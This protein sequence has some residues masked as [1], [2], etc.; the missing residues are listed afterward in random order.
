MKKNLPSFM[1][2]VV[3]VALSILTG[4]TVYATGFNLG[5]FW[6][7]NSSV[8]P[9]SVSAVASV[10]PNDGLAQAFLII[11]PRD[12]G[13]IPY[14]AGATVEV[15]SS[16][17]TVTMS[18]NGACRT[19]NSY[20][21]KAYDAGGGYYYAYA[22]SSTVQSPTFSTV[23]A[24]SPDYNTGSS[25]GVTFDTSQYTTIS[26]NTTITN[27]AHGGRNLY[28]TGGTATF[29]STTVGQTFGI[30][31][32]RGGTIKH[33]ATTTA[34]MYKLDVNAASLFLQSGSI[35][36]DALGYTVT[37]SF[38]PTTPAT[39]FGPSS[40][41]AGSHG[42]RGGGP[43]GPTGSV[44]GAP[45]DDYRNPSY[46]GGG[47][48]SG[49]GIGGG[50][51]RI[52]ASGACAVQSGATIT[53]NAGASSGP[54][55]AGG[56]VYLNCA[57]FAGTAG[58]NAITAKGI[59]PT[60]S[61]YSG[62]GGRIAL[63]STGNAANFTGNFNYNAS[64]STFKTMVNA[65]GGRPFSSSYGGGGAG[66][67]Y[68]KHTGLT[69]GD[70]I[71]NNNSQTFALYNRN[72]DLVS[73]YGT[74]NGAPGATTLPISSTPTLTNFVNFYGGL[75]LRPDLSFSNGTASD[76]SDDNVLT[77]A[78]N[79][80]TTLTMNA[81]FSGVANGASFR[82][83][84]MFDHLEVTDT[85]V[86]NSYGDIYV[87]SGSLTSPGPAL[88]LTNA[89]L[90]FNAS[91]SVNPS[92]T[93]YTLSSGNYTY[94]NMTGINITALN[95]VLISGATVN[96]G[97]MT[98]G[99][100][101]LSSGTVTATTISAGAMSV[102]GGTN[103]LQNIGTTGDLTI[104]GGTMNHPA[105]DTTT[106]Y[107]LQATVGGNFLMSGGSINTDNLGYTAGYSFGASGPSN[108]LIP[109]SYGGSHGGRGG[110]STTGAAT[111]S[112]FDDY[113]N[114]NYPGGGGGSGGGKGGGVVR[115]TTTGSCTVNSGATITANAGSNSANTG[116]GGS[117]Y[118]NCASF[119]G[120]AGAGAITAKSNA[121]TGTYF[122]GGGGRIA[123]I[124]AGNASSFTGNFDYNGALATFKSMVNA[125]GGRPFNT[126]YGGGGAG[127]I[128]IKHSGLTYGDML[129][130]NN[131]QTY[132][133]SN[134]HTDLLSMYGTVNA[135][136]GATTLPVSAT[137]SVVSNYVNVYA[138]MKVRPDLAFT[139]GTSTDWSDDNVLTVASNNGSG[140]L[141]M[142][143]S[144]SGVANGASF[145]SIDI[146]DHLEV[147][148]T[149]VVNSYGDIYVLNGSLTSPG[150][151]L[152]LTNALLIFNGSASINP[153][154]S[155]YTFS[156][157]D[158]SYTAAQGTSP[159]AQNNIVV[160]G[161]IVNFATVTAGSFSI[162][163][164][165]MLATTISAGSVGVSG[166]T[167][168][169]Q[170]ITTTGDLTISGG[171]VNHPTTTTT[172]V[173]RLQATVGGNFLMSGGT[174]NVTALGYTAGYSFGASGPSNS[175]IPASYGG[176]HGGR[177]G[178]STTGG[179][180]AAPF[181]D[182]RNPNYPG[183]G[184]G[185][186]GSAGGGVVR[187][188]ATGSCTINSGA[189]IAAN[190]NAWSGNTGAGGSIYL[191][192][193]SFAGTAG[194]GAITAKSNASTSTYFSG[195]GGR[196]ALISTGNAASF[197]GNFAYTTGLTTFKSMVNAE[198]G[199]PYNSGYGGGGAGTIYIKHSGLTYG[200]M[201]INNN[202][203]TYGASNANTDLISMY[204]TVNGAPGATTL[205]VSSTPTLASNY[206]N[207]Y[208]GMRLRPDLTYTN[209]TSSDWTDDNVLTVASN[210]SSV[211][212]MTGSFSG[213]A[214][215][216]SFRSIDIFD[217]LEVSDTSVVNSYGDIYVLSGSLTS[218]GSMSL[219]NAFIT[220]NGS[221]SL[222]PAVNDYTFSSGTVG[223]STTNIA[224]NN[225]T[226]SGATATFGTITANAIS[227]SSGTMTATTISA[228]SMGVSGGTTTVQN[229]TTTGD[230]TISGG[231]VNHPA[232]TT[233][234]VYRLQATVG[235]NFLMSGGS[236]NVNNLGYTNGYSFGSPNPITA[237]ASGGSSG[238]SHGG[239][240]GYIAAG[241]TY[242]DYRNPNLPGAG[243]AGS[244]GGVVRIT[245]TGSCTI[246]SGASITANGQVAAQGSAGG[247]IYM[248]C[249]SF[250]GT[251]GAAAISAKGGTANSTASG[252][253][254]RIALISTGNAASFSG[255][256]DYNGALATFKST[257]TAEGGRVFSA[258]YGGG[259]AGT[260]YL[261]HSGLTFGDMLINNNSQTYS[262]VTGNTDLV[263]MYG[264]VNG[265]PGATTLPV[266]ATPALNGNYVNFYAGMK[267]RPDLAYTNGTASDWSD[268]N[269]VTV[270]SNNSGILTMTASFSG[271]AN[272]ASFRSID[273]F[274]H[275]ELTA[276]STVGTYGDIYVLNG[277]ITS[278]GPTLSLTNAWMTFYGSGSMNPAV[279]DYTF[280][281]GTFNA[282]GNVTSTNFTVSG[283]TVT[284]ATITAGAVSVSSG[285]LTA[286]NITTT[287]DMTISGGT[288]S[289][290]L[291]TASTVY[292]LQ[293][294]VGGN[295]L[296]SGGSINVNNLG[297]PNSYSFGSP[298]P[299]TA[300]APGG[301]SGA[302]HGGKGGNT[303][304]GITYD[305]YRNPN[306]PG[307]GAAGIGGGVVRITTTGSCTINSGASI[308]ANGQVGATG[309]AGGSI[310]MNCAS[311][312]GTAGAAAISAKGGTANSTA[313]GGGGRIALI[314]TG[315]AAS[316]SGNF[317]YNG[318]LATFKSTVTAEGG[319]MFSAPYGGGGAG[320]IYLKHSGL[321]YGDML[322]N[323][324][325]Q[326]Y[327]AVNGTTD[328]VSMY[329][330]VNG[331][332][333][334]T[335]L[336]VSSTPALN[337]N[338]VNFYPGM[339]LRPDLAN[340]NGT[341]ND[342]SDD[343]VVT[344]ASN[345]SGI[346]TMTASFAGV[347]NGASFRSI[348]I[349]DH[350]EITDTSIISSY[351]DIY[352]LNGSITSPGSMSFT[353]GAITFIG[354]ASM[355]PT[356]DY[357]FSSGTLNV[358]AN[359]LPST[360]VIVSGGTVSFATITASAVSVSSGTMTVQSLTT[361]GDLTISGGTV[362][363]LATTASTAYKL[364]ATVGGNFLMSGGSINVNN[365]GYLS[366]YSY[367]SASPS[368]TLAASGNSGGSHG[369]KGSY[370]TPGST[371]D[372]FRNP[373][374]P[375]AGMGAGAGGGVVRITTTGSCTINSGASITAN[376]QS[377][378]QGSA[379]GSIY[380]NCASFGGTAGAGAITAK[381]GT[382][383]STGS[384]GGGRIA[385]ISTGNAASFSGSFD[386]VT[387]LASF[388][389][390][391][392]AEGGRI[393][394]ATYGGGGAGTIY[395]KH[396]GLT[397]G[398]M[399][400]DNNSLAANAQNGKTALVLSTAN[401]STIYSSTATK[402]QITNASTPLANMTDLFV[403][404]RLH[405]FTTASPA[406]PLDASHYE[407]TVT[408][409]DANN[410]WA[411]AAS[412]PA[413]SNNHYYRFVYK[414]D[415]LEISGNST[416]DIAGG[417]LMLMTTASQPC[418]LHSASNAQFAVPAGSSVNGNSFASSYCS[419]ALVS[420]TVTFTN[421]YL[422]P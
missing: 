405:V 245:T 56:S 235:G 218:P 270:A 392:T 214:N 66:T 325:S 105:T 107:R 269:V 70:M 226:F 331:A 227:V 168:T 18:G 39:T 98:A 360:N 371:Y 244:G 383:T 419:A 250:G 367:G 31:F 401:S 120:T 402:L 119:A 75:K 45:F 396:S 112:P 87:L 164:G 316:F 193:A 206:V 15:T 353:N 393:F 217:H 302:S 32:V 1:K 230:M 153:V 280:S 20:C 61:A 289:H 373:S 352:V 113:R 62:A 386:Y 337:G 63:I 334:A 11:Y 40:S 350:V 156:S 382:A 68:I 131:G 415:H 165:N 24:G 389:A 10:V 380:L 345:N 295:F 319:R 171:L 256:F 275:F 258:T 33:T 375:G 279:S 272:G 299:L 80:S 343:N 278:P 198:G 341:A 312:A 377:A 422:Q 347:A 291:T 387:S 124:S 186:G 177:G 335:T 133:T 203:Q 344:V 178:G 207:V 234:T 243:A 324:N 370:T 59:V 421:T 381:G 58:A 211:L 29:D 308:T 191:N 69:Y 398:D 71:V 155:N 339:K 262:A 106:V 159:T 104:S 268:D 397:Y 122:S 330:T 103:T 305:D 300:F 97:T 115:I 395:L 326:T 309:G 333:G 362:N 147:T 327:S 231:T 286:Q 184:G 181:D 394:S 199:R 109:A 202:G 311:F 162:S 366:G 293:A 84:D 225:I 132:G 100:V 298:N 16:S 166:G 273:M 284:F 318:A 134:A 174:I 346:L 83:I 175:L 86:V 241:I 192:C 36:A 121:T 251:A 37:Y 108:S 238:G 216:A 208:A 413:I 150:P 237:F 48:S 43:S 228:G 303:L 44:T 151:T 182:Y 102:S 35:N 372:D 55:G 356:P 354:S 404:H 76:W 357:T 219:T 135:V 420:G 261:K 173:Y 189:S 123:F 358:S 233:T 110:G 28:F 101:S 49:G 2:A 8:T 209:G 310:Y 96:F 388:K 21:T 215:G 290:P 252:G 400:I 240:G 141:T 412:F 221:G 355:Y 287:G 223:S 42:G 180:T 30:L 179:A 47:G 118:M 294:T 77:V 23:V 9:T 301:N 365:L 288:L 416:L 329:G 306:Y 281:S 283:A 34:T 146:F 51:V 349:F 222:Y 136:P 220:F 348:D 384:G 417:D 239:A 14:G 126:S 317:D 17:T 314:S 297:Y 79:S 111:A 307:G 260:I 320:T 160:S 152:S 242:D 12:V 148:N 3:L 188:T 359:K 323:N 82:S 368:T 369:G 195:G 407:A 379:G 137:P 176:S 127:T 46:P 204:G 274:D 277:S 26:A 143:A 253:G 27:A 128:Y 154:I 92:I 361:T 249:A 72:T 363:H 315:N 185:S 409:N 194:A 74:V 60:G 304:A 254:G 342:W 374:Y 187:I 285:S 246:N 19:P 247:S 213:V 403:G 89:L 259:G 13:G 338:Y 7:R 257:V 292:R 93:N 157:G 142:T 332:P 390:M 64:L 25:V 200:D 408:S 169:I 385:L 414:L 336:P 322:I 170:N 224:G 94:Y 130:N 263:S 163:S 232:T 328:L 99:S 139:N 145:R 144:F 282:G 264:T 78:S 167:S 196:I 54:T 276:S 91:A 4:L 81:S 172:T 129:I 158:F 265:A 114:P 95:N 65:E 41:D 205:P 50:V 210:T 411:T 73:M 248:N 376:G 229:I 351:G 321:T 117:I 406:N 340:T 410:F 190:A 266:S 57:T 67:I 183:G 391:V 138:G 255:N 399:I 378:A 267:L 125:E 88:S 201:I 197:T 313:S 296:M 53:A 6:K 38:G 236:I 364:Q 140:V 161:A 116:A 271:V 212:T 5:A 52:T 90:T 418:D 85:S 149:S 22:T